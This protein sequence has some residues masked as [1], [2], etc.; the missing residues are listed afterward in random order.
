VLR[1]VGNSAVAQLNKEPLT[2][3]K[4]MRLNLVCVRSER[5]A[6]FEDLRYEHCATTSHCT[7]FFFY[8]RK[9]SLPLI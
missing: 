3:R 8:V 7:F 2:S 5:M 6:D 9:V 4:D 1:L